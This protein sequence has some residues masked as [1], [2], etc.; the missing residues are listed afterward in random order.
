MENDVSKLQWLEFDQLKPYP[1]IK[2]ASFARHGGVSNGLFA[3]L[4]GSTEVGD[5]PDCVKVNREKMAQMLQAQHLVFPH[6]NHGTKVI[7]ITRHNFAQTHQADALYTTEKGIALG[8]T[9]ADCQAAI[10]YDP[11]HEAIAIAHAGWRGNVQNIYSQ[12]IDQLR[13]E[14]EADPKDLLVCISP[15]LGPCHAEFKSYKQDL[16][17]SFW[18][19]QVKPHYFDFWKIS[20]M[21]LIASGVL[22]K[23]IE[24]AQVCTF[25]AS[26]DYFSYRYNSKGGR[27][28]TAVVLQEGY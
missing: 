3:S 9:H 8:V 17:Q 24:L 11:K 19:F 22:E 18:S 7:R 25:C 4:N 16:P 20:Q 12:L 23:N 1:R 26:N 14:I 2:H 13:Q 10:F 28:A 27:N 15:S 5:H 21:Q 6:Q